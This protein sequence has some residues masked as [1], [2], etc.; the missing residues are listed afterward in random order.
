METLENGWSK[1]DYNGTEAYIKTEFLE[2]VEG[3]PT[4]EGETTEGETAAG[5]TTEGEGGTETSSATTATTSGKVTVKATVNIRES[6]SETG[7]RLG[8]AYRG[9]QF[10]LIEKSGDWCKITYKGQTAYVKADFVE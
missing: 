6:A 9:E 3:A 7:N 4:T 10:D 1:I 2:V 8:V 5:E